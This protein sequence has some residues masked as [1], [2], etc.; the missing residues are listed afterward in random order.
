MD[1]VKGRDASEGLRGKVDPARRRICP[2][3]LRVALRDHAGRGREG[4]G[5]G[6]DERAIEVNDLLDQRLLVKLGEPTEVAGR[7]AARGPPYFS[8][9]EGACT[10]VECRQAGGRPVDGIGPAA[11][12]DADEVSIGPVTYS[13]GMIAIEGTICCVPR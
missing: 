10:D 9:H 3:V 6:D 2:N 1:T 8:S 7:A 12:C 4:L 13:N 11:M 5:F